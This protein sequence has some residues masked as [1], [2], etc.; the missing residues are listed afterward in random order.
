MSISKQADD[1]SGVST[2]KSK[3]VLNG[4]SAF[5]LSILSFQAPLS[6]AAQTIP[7][8]NLSPVNLISQQIPRFEPTPSTVIPT[9][10]VPLAGNE[11]RQTFGENLQLR[12]MQ[13]LPANLY[14][15]SNTDT[16]FRIETNVFQTPTKR[17][18]INHSG[19][20]ALG[21]AGKTRVLESLRF[22]SQEDQV[23]RVLPNTTLGWA[24]TPHT[25]VYA[26]YFMLR[27]SLFHNTELNTTIHSVGGGFQH[28]IPIGRRASLQ[29]DFQGR[30]LFQ[31]QRDPL[32]D[33]LPNLTFSYLVNPKTIAFTSALLQLRGNKPFQAPTA[34][35]DP[36]YSFG[37][38]HRRGGWI[39]TNT[40]TF[41]QNFREPFR[42]NA[43]I[44]VN[45]YSWVLDFEVARRLSKK[46][47][48]L[49]AFVRA[50]PIYNFHSKGVFGLS[51]MDFRFF[52]GLRLQLAK[53]A[54]TATL[55]QIKEQL[56]EQEA[57]P[58]PP[59]KNLSR[60]APN[61][62]GSSDCNKTIMPYELAAHSPQPMHGF[63]RTEDTEPGRI[64]PL[65]P[66]ITAATTSDRILDIADADP[67]NVSTNDKQVAIHESG[68]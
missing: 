55:R 22:V 15:T 53:P 26:N 65:R 16:T 42:R 62:V 12:I 27:D 25:R 48:G 60:H 63:I 39:F 4:A 44:R 20:A 31:S 66:G 8:H 33:Y 29:F 41:L 5:A 6:S 35:I 61:T 23:F 30:E 36:F 3:A 10:V 1:R 58:P 49:F 59:V 24:L 13:K 21:L 68:P 19:F 9:D 64:V 32:W 52:Y 47:P 51:G 56:E 40:A 2:R 18:V 34:E 17:S 67:R 54:L 38:V 7:K 28:D 14:F 37:F 11:E 50:E 46:V 45:S 43:I 57:E